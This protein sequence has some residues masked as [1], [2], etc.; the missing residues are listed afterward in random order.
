MY[1]SVFDPTSHY[2]NRHEVIQ[3][4]VFDFTGRYTSLSVST[5]CL[6]KYRYIW[7]IRSSGNCYSEKNLGYM[8]EELNVN[9][10]ESNI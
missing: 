10:I 6:F 5:V 4:V 9:I 2:K 3:V 7:A 8:R 1:K